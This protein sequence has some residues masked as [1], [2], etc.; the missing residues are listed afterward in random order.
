MIT[1]CTQGGILVENGVGGSERA[2]S[3]FKNGIPIPGSNPSGEC[4][5][6][7]SQAV[8]FGM[9]SMSTCMIKMNLQELRKFC[10]WLIQDLKAHQVV[11]T[12]CRLF[13]SVATISS[14]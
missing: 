3:A 14:V 12:Q 5:A 4:A 9:T 8:K 7:S 11:G 13:V 6:A 2:I 1:L 10:R